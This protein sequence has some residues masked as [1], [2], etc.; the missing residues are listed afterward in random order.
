[1]KGLKHIKKINEESAIFAQLIQNYCEKTNKEFMKQVTQL[2]KDIALGEGLD[3]D[4]L[5]QKYIKGS[6]NDDTEDD[7]TTINTMDTI[8]EDDALLDKIIFH[9]TIYY[10][11]KK[12]GNIVYDTKSNIIGKYQ[13]GKV[14][15]SVS[16]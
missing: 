14:V 15:L 5:K 13:D 1:M 11:D 9:N 8:E 12:N 4:M 3:Y 2:I 7:P 10:V 16:T 6:K